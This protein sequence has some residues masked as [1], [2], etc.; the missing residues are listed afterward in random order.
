MG[1]SDCSTCF[2]SCLWWMM[3]CMMH[4]VFVKVEIHVMNMDFLKA[5]YN[6]DDGSVIGQDVS[7]AYFGS[8]D[9]SL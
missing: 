5:Q 9:G 2:D 4:V 6:Y 3:Q 1:D 8:G 7:G